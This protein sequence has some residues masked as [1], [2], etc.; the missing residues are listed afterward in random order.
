MLD[1]RRLVSGQ[2][3]LPLRRPAV[4]ALVALAALPTVAG[5]RSIEL[6]LDLDCSLRAA[7]A[8]C[9]ARLAN[10]GTDVARELRYRIEA[11]EPS[12]QWS[13]PED[14]PPDAR[15]D[16]EHAVAASPERSRIVTLRAE[17]LDRFGFPNGALTALRIRTPTA[18]AAAGLVV[19]LL[20]GSSAPGGTV[21]LRLTHGGARTVRLVVRA[22]APNGLVIEPERLPVELEPGSERLLS[23]SVGATT[24]APGSSYGAFLTVERSEDG[25]AVD[26]LPLRIDLPVHAAEPASI[27]LARLALF[28]LLAL[29]AAAEIPGLRAPR[30]GAPST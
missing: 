25:A 8:G 5:A 13:A 23:F 3:T 19:E 28:A 9:R 30:A 1:G 11:G 7:D 4:W 18:A 6:Q 29:M 17:Y 20:D 12:P 24:A 21:G 14:L 27:G 10:R 2:R 15:L 22:L 26:L 16:H